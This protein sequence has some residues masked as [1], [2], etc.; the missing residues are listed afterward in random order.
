M[1]ENEWMLYPTRNRIPL[2]Q[3][4]LSIDYGMIFVTG[5]QY[6]VTEIAPLV[7]E[8]GPG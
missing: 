4:Y 1:V 5:F 6:Y 8:V 2:N 3:R 7:F